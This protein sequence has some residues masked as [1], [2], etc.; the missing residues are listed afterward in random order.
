VRKFDD[1]YKPEVKRQVIR[2]IEENLSKGQQNLF[3]TDIVK[4]AEA[5]YDVMVTELKDRFIE[6]PRMDLVQGEVTASFNHFDLDVSNL[7]YH[8]LEQEI[9]RLGLLDKQVETLKQNQAGLMGILLTNNFR[10]N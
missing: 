2:K 4:E 3:K 8:A 5:V 1:Y 7:N 6:I 10:V 9:I